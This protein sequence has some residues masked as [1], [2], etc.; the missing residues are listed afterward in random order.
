MR[1]DA[2]FR[3]DGDPRS[4]SPDS[5]AGLY[6]A[7][8]AADLGGLMTNFGIAARRRHQESISRIESSDDLAGG[9]GPSQRGYTGGGIGILSTGNHPASLM[10]VTQGSPCSVNRRPD[11]SQSQHS[12][13][14]TGTRKSVV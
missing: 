8:A 6:T 3:R 11:P 10:L 12:K 9:V 14:R 2:I 7:C 1:R 13:T 5:I 4:A